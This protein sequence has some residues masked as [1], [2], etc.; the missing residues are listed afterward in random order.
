M[1]YLKRKQMKKKNTKFRSCERRIQCKEEYKK[2]M[3]DPKVFNFM[4]ERD[5]L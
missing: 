1:N 3:V 4:K 2:K 5:L